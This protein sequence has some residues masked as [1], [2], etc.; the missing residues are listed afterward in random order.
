MTTTYERIA[1]LLTE[2]LGV[3]EDIIRPD[4]TLTD[5]ELDSLS[6]VELSVIIQEEFGVELSEED[7]KPTLGEFCRIVEQRRD[8][9]EAMGADSSRQDVSTTPTRP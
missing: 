6:I 7:L 3:P 8:G 5:L 1:G 4:A 9:S 2:H